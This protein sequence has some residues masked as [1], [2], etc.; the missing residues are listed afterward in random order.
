MVKSCNLYS[1]DKVDV[2]LEMEQWAERAALASAAH[3]AHLF[4]SLSCFYLRKLY[5]MNLQRPSRGHKGL[6]GHTIVH[7]T[8]AIEV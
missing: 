6:G 4:I 2:A 5:V 7:Q 8:Q 1:V 3:K